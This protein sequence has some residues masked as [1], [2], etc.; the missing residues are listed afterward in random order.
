MGAKT[1]DCDTLA[2]EAV[3]PGKPALRKI[4]T[5]FGAGVFSGRSLNRKAMADIIF[6]SPVARK[7]LEAIIHPEVIKK[8]KKAIRNHRKGLLVIDIPLLFES[9]LQSLTDRTLVVWVPRET[10]VRRL[11]RRDTLSRAEAMLR[12]RSQMPI[13]KKRAL[14]DFTIDNSKSF[15]S[16]A[17]QAREYHRSLTSC[18]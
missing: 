17:R 3:L 10:Q 2:R 7:K 9:K 15:R 18:R 6:K 12:I 14:A 13:N 5:T 11:M 4:R 16:T 8:L 1:L